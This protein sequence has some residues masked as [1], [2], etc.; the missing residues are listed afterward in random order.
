[1][2]ERAEKHLPACMTK[3]VYVC[4]YVGAVKKYVHVSSGAAG[5][6]A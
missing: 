3:T 6:Q 4:E 2:T 1:M 5:L